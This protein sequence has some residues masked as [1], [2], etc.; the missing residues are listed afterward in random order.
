MKKCLLAAMLLLLATALP[1]HGRERVS[2]WCEQGGNT[3]TTGGLPSTEDVQESFAS[4]TVTIYDVGTLDLASIFSDDSGTVKAN[5]FTA[6]ST[7]FW[8]FLADDARYDLRFSGGGIS[9]PFTIGDILLDDTK[10]DVTTIVSVASSATPTFD[11]SLGTIYTNTLTANVTSSTISNPVTGQRIT[12]YLAQDGTGGWTFA[13][14]ANVQ[15]RKGGYTISDDASAVSTIALYYDGTNWREL[16]RGPDEEFTG[17]WNDIRTVDGDKFTTCQAADDD[18]G[19]SNGLII[20]PSTYTGAECTTIGANVAILDLRNPSGA[21]SYSVGLHR[22][23]GLAN[24]KVFGAKGDNSTDDSAAINAAILHASDNNLPG[25]FIPPGRYLACN[26]NMKA[27]VDVLGAGVHT[28]DDGHG[29]LLKQQSTTCDVLVTDTALADIG[30]QHWTK[31][32]NL[33][34]R[35]NPS[36]T[37]GNGIK[38][39]S[40]SGEGFKLEYLFITDMPE[41]GVRAVEGHVP[42]Y[43]EDLHFFNNGQSSGA[44]YGMDINPGSGDC[45]AMV[46]LNHISGDDNEDGLIRI[47]ETTGCS[48]VLIQAVKSESNTAGKQ[49]NTIVLDNLNGTAVVI[50]GVYQS[51]GV[52]SNAVIQV[53]G[54][55]GARV[56]WSGIRAENAAP[57]VTN[58]LDDQVQG[59]T[60]AANASGASDLSSGQ[61]FNNFL[62]MPLRPQIVT[63]TDGGTTPAVNIGGG[64][65]KTANTGATTITDFDGVLLDGFI[66]TILVEDAN[67]TF[68]DTGPI[69]MRAGSNVKASNGDVLQ[70]VSTQ[71]GTVWVELP[72][73]SNAFGVQRTFIGGA[74]LVAGDFVLSAGWGTTATIGGLVTGAGSHDA[75]GSFLVTSS[76]TGQGANPTV[77]FTFKDGAWGTAPFAIVVRSGGDQLSVVSTWTTTTTTLVLTFNGTPVAAE[78]YTFS[79]RIWQ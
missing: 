55:T 39:N 25:I 34:I 46:Y 66:I 15:L 70:F 11:A 79:Y 26:I 53:I 27:Q 64:V 32:S 17:L 71:N 40:R 61:N 24:V 63:F 58:I 43:A 73:S 8:F 48:S 12:L 72:L 38:L 41:S 16:N 37:L 14:P 33:T 18:L 50:N 9:T 10:N 78:T 60:V 57:G 52:S 59:I 23:N 6:S 49:Q 45:N 68:S 77:T 30:F 54:A 22:L 1:A 69:E 20:I 19:A 47:K 62:A 74:A 75:R 28:G 21:D 13:W 56:K 7:G 44:G 5:P 42:F 36:G 51:N 4:C 3:I 76:G 65:F 35:G 31:I 67:T 2:G 29:T